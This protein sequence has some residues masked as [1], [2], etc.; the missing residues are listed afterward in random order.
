[1]SYQ[2]YIL[3]HFYHMETPMSEEGQSSGGD[4]RRSDSQS[5][6]TDNA[7]LHRVTER[8]IGSSVFKIVSAACLG[9]VGIGIGFGIMGTI[10]INGAKADLHADFRQV[11]EAA[12]Q[13]KK[14]IQDTRDQTQKDLRDTRDQ[15]QNYVRDVRQDTDRQ[16]AEVATQVRDLHQATAAALTKTEENVSK[17]EASKAKMEA[18]AVKTIVQELQSQ[19]SLLR[20]E[21]DKAADEW[22]K[23]KPDLDD[24]KKIIEENPDLKT[25]VRDAILNSKK[26]LDS[27]IDA[28][29]SQG[30][31][32]D[33]QLL[34]DK[35][36]QNT[37]I[38]EYMTQ[39]RLLGS[40]IEKLKS[41]IQ[42]AGEKVVETENTASRFKVTIND[43]PNVL[44]EMNERIQGLDQKINAPEKTPPPPANC[45]ERVKSSDCARI[46]LALFKKV[47]QP[48]NRQRPWEADN[49]GEGGPA[50]VGAIHRYLDTIKAPKADYLT[51]DQLRQL[52]RETNQL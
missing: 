21:L 35:I 30:R 29:L 48:A 42:T 9:A 23:L 47:G 14:D 51:P 44:K 16:R 45:V 20:K 33:A 24:L 40:E 17:F 38:N 25:S 18:E 1:M 22:K 4:D 15:A 5:M 27:A 43:L 10:E 2:L 26:A 50:T 39:F 37:A 19:N 52:L 28:Q 7:V 36:L 49:D 46:Q 6:Q 3:C 12:N 41:K 13:T 32:A 31:A 34:I 11:Q 8:F